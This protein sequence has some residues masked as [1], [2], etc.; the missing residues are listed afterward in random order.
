LGPYPWYIFTLEG[1]LLLFS[2]FAW[3]I[4]RRKEHVSD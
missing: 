3:L 2:F 1:L 4:S